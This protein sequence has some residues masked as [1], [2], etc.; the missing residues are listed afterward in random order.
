MFRLH[1]LSLK[2]HPILNDVDL[3]FF[4]EDSKT[5]SEDLYTTVLIGMNGTGK[6][7]ILKTIADLF[8]EVN[9]LIESKSRQRI[10][11]TFQIRYS[12]NDVIYDI[13]SSQGVKIERKGSVR[14]NVLGVFALR[15]RPIQE[16][17]YP[18][19]LSFKVLDEY[20][21]DL[22]EA[23]LPS[24][25]IVSTSQLKDRFTFKKDEESDFYKYCGVKR[26]A[27]NIST[28]SYKR[29]TADALLINLDHAN[30]KDT[31]GSALNEYLGFDSFLKIHFRTKYTS[32]FFDGELTI[33]KLEDFYL[34]FG[35]LGKRKTEPWGTWKFKQLLSKHKENY[36][37]ERI[38]KGSELSELDNLINFINRLR[39]EGHLEKVDNTDSKRLS[40]DFFDLLIEGVNGSILTD[41]QQL[42][43]IYLE[44]IELQKNDIPVD[45]DK[46]SAGEN[47]I[48]MSLLTILSKIKEG[49]LVLIDE[50]EISLHPNW[51]MSYIDLLTNMFKK[52]TNCHFVI[53]THSHFMISNLRQNTSNV[54][55][56]HRDVGNRLIVDPVKSDTFGWS[57][58]DILYRVFEVKTYRNFY[59]ERDLRESL[60]MISER[61]VDRDKLVR[62]YERLRS[63]NLDSDDPVNLVLDKIQSYL[64]L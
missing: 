60:S 41:L 39:P 25:I 33:E 22:S 30:F 31:L 50:P 7:Y 51:Q 40:I 23:V 17:I 13:V 19:E 32:N 57:A 59:V 62:N 42:D 15:G 63:L 29:N 53:A 5:Y 43:L 2:G 38:K 24:R 21:I 55:A 47:Q 14:K 36:K 45:F 34:N 8:F 1:S 58:E 54:I 52:F 37:S 4:D 44:W 27:R 18:E 48:I 6:S 3:T 56:L 16:P 12:V 35:E 9:R 10:P 64:E 20:E 11:F 46:A 28:N 61:N 26:T 49:S